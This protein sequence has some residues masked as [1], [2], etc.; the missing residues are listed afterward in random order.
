MGAMGGMGGGMG[1]MGGMGGGGG[2]GVEP[3]QEIVELMIPAN[4]VG[5][6]I[7]KTSF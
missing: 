2:G 5:L 3:G 1:G 7:G 4:K 6:I